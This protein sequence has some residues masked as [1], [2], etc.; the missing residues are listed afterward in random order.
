MVRS[1]NV[2]LVPSHGLEAASTK[3]AF[4]GM[5]NVADFEWQVRHDTGLEF[6]TFH[7]PFA[8]EYVENLNQGGLSR[9]A[10]PPQFPPGLMESDTS[11]Q[12]D[13]GATFEKAY[14][15]NFD[16]GLVQKP[17]DFADRTYYKENVC[18]DSYGANSLYNWELFFHAPLYIATRLS[19]N[20]KHEEAMQWFHYIFDPTTDE[21]PAAGQLET[22]RY[23]KVLPFKTQPAKSLEDWFRSL[24]PNA[25]S[26]TENAIIEEWRDNPFDPHRVASNRPLAYMKHVVIK[27]VENLIAWGDSLFRQFARES[28]SE[29][30]QIYVIAN[31][32]LGPRPEFVPKRGEITTESYSSLQ[33]KWDDFSNALVEL[34][35]IF[36]YSS[37]ANVGSSSTGTRLL[38]VGS[39][40]YFCIPANDKLID[41]W[42]TVTDRLDKIRHCKD[43]DGVERKLALFAP[44][45]EPSALIQA[46]AQ[47][48]SLGS[49]LADLSSPPPLYRF[50]H[51][52]QKAHELCADVKALGSTL[53]AALEKK[54]A[55]E[56]G[57]LRA[58]HE[59]QMLDLITAV[60]ERQVLEAKAHKE[61]LDKA[62]TTASFRLQ[63][64]IDLLGNDSV[65]V[66]ATP[67]VSATLTADS[68]LPAD[69]NLVTIKTDV[70][71]SLVDS[72]ESGVKLIP[73]EKE[74]L[75]KLEAAHDSQD[76]ANVAELIASI[77]HALP[78]WVFQSQ[79]LGIGGSIKWGTSH[80]GYAISAVAK[81]YQIDAAN[82]SFDAT[83]AAKYSQYIRREQDWTLQANLAAR[84]IIQLDKQITAADIRIQVTEKELAN[85]KQQIDNAEE[86]ED[87]LKDK[88][89]NQE[90]YQWMKEQLFAVYKQS[91][92]LAFD[93]AK[94]AEKAYTLE[95]GTE[96]A[97]FI[98]YG[99]WDNSQQ[100][101]A[102]G[103]KLQLAL[104]Q[105]EKSYL[106]NNRRELEISKSISL[107]RL[108]PLA[109]IEL[110]E[111]GK[112][113][114]SVPEELFDLDFRGHYF[115]RIKAVRLTIP[116]VAGPYASVSCTLRLLKSTVRINTAKNSKGGYEHENDEGLW[117]DD[118]RFRTSY[119]PV[120]SIATSLAQNDSGT[121]EFSFRDERYLPF[122]LAG[123][124]SEWQIELST[125]DEELKLRAFDYAT[126]SDVI[127]HLNYTARETGGSFKEDA[128]TYVKGFL[129]NTDD[130]TE[131]PLMQ[132]FSLRHEFPAEWHKF[133]RPSTAG[134]DQ[135][136]N[137]TLGKERF[138]YLAQNRDIVV[139]EI[140]VFARC[141]QATSYDV[142][143]SYLDFDDTPISSSKITM[144][145]SKSYG[146]LNT[147]TV[148]VNDTD[149][150]D[151]EEKMSLQLKR[152][153]A[154]DYKN[155]VTTPDDE[156]TDILLVLHYKLQDKQL[157]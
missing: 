45:I 42:D 92:N 98:Q 27:Y 66:P 141:T 54:D 22:A 150:L 131:Q 31:H 5:L 58:S 124:I 130:L 73:K 12:S 84:E 90:L 103:E 109:L 155:L 18:F 47:G 107:A 156:V 44:P 91:Y 39:A 127:L 21:T 19:K 8:S 101:L 112:C 4:V 33:N 115:R 9:G 40:L 114:V 93:M 43:I 67:T 1:T 37:Q 106:E 61:N 121:F 50:S 10:K 137:F 55:E 105:M 16:Y 128:T 146:Q 7:H 59:T 147:A 97:N 95:L 149:Q 48:L 34:E 51:L 68:Q 110:R 72:E 126:I 86:V 133:L 140:D 111:T 17:A 26:Q 53:L 6:H 23:W 74:E 76:S 82:Q 123:A 81:G 151:I 145:Q 83:L 139:T 157:S 132:L 11:I 152:S 104:R 138:P 78:D 120:T 117:T 28:V 57:R 36:P 52:S 153:T 143:L 25:N 15:P 99:Y 75:V 35:N 100:G 38:G 2:S 122:E 116:C 144:S 62:R 24:L 65:T 118:N 142:L 87:F 71:E 14:A 56:L 41:Y 79:P 108:N 85:H 30:L 29:A 64:Y 113:S 129:K 32:I 134:A 13:E 20:G 88:F 77:W 135:S 60:R 70:D 3:N 148:K 136:L 46:A 154:A 119:T 89:T 80:L 125:D 63:H 69:T 49:I 102:A 94:K 96:L